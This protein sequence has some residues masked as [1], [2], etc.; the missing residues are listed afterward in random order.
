MD[1]RNLPQLKET[2]ARRLQQAQYKKQ[3]IL[4]YAGITIGLSA[5]VTIL[6]Y[7]LSNQISQTGGLSNMGT[8]TILSTLQSLLPIVQSMVSLM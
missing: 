4:I 5:L 6:T 7:L 8:R 1:I 3:I 2:A